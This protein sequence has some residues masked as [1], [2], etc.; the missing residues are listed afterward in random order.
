MSDETEQD[1]KTERASERRLQS[2]RENG[3]IAVS[4]DVGM[5]AT[6][7]AGG[8]VLTLVGAEIGRAHV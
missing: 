4:R 6:L 5:L 3:D 2:A 1:E 8:A 7:G